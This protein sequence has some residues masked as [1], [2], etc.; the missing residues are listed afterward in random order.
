MAK[1]P[2][3]CDECQNTQCPMQS[4]IVREQC[5]MF[6]DVKK[7]LHSEALPDM[8]K[9]WSELLVAIMRFHMEKD[10]IKEVRSMA[11]FEKLMEGTIHDTRTQG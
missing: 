11:E 6:Q 3:I 7:V 10:L 5:F 4:G 1:R 9:L 2:S 8:N